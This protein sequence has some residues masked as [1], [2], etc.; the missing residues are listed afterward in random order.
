MKFSEFKEKIIV[1]RG[2][3]EWERIENSDEYK[4]Y[5]APE[6]EQLKI[7]K[8]AGYN[9]AFINNPSLKVQFY[10]IR[11]DP[12]AIQYIDNPIEELQLEAIKKNPFVIGYMKNPT[13]DVLKEA[14]KQ[15]EYDKA[16][17]W[18]Y[19]DFFKH[20]ENDLKE[21]RKVKNDTI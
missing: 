7:V 20:L 18:K 12:Y 3:E 16:P 21:E 17:T 4:I 9:I 14:I 10:A 13:E 6:E 11:K 8:R 19:I 15:M 2:K 1:T 5:I